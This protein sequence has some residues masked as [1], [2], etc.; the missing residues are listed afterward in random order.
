MFWYYYI[1][2]FEYYKTIMFLCWNIIIFEYYNTI[3][4]WYYSSIIFEYYNTIMFWSGVRMLPIYVFSFVVVCSCSL[5]FHKL[6]SNATNSCL[7]IGEP[8]WEVVATTPTS[9]ADIGISGLR[10]RRRQAFSTPSFAYHCMASLP[11]TICLQALAG[12]QDPKR[13]IRRQIENMH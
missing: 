9:H 1:I 2:A 7:S 10:C 12:I 6:C 4:F 13:S 8:A 11:N 3:M 5:Q